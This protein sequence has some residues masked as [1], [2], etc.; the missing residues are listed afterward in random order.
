MY[1]L[2]PPALDELGLAGRSSS[3]GAGSRAAPAGLTIA[4][5]APPTASAP[6]PAA[7]EVAA[8][9]IATEAL[10]NVSRHAARRTCP[11]RLRRDGALVLEVTDDGR[12]LPAD[13]RPASA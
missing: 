13:R 8:Y 3:S 6:L 7:V 1:G 4:V 12:G 10:T 9:R 11:V 2:R 5:A